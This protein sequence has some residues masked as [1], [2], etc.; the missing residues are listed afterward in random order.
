MFDC[1]G[2]L[3]KAKIKVIEVKN[4]FQKTCFEGKKKITS[5]ETC[6]FSINRNLRDVLKIDRQ[7]VVNRE[8]RLI[9]IYLSFIWYSIPFPFIYF[10]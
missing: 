7:E 1:S 10:A 9:Y 4:K 5:Y 8:T 2:G 6:D 3:Q